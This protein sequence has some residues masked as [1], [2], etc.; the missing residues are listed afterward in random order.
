MILAV[1]I[2]WSS[3]QTVFKALPLH[4]DNEL[5][6]LV[7]LGSDQYPYKVRQLYAIV[8]HL[9]TCGFLGC[10]GFAC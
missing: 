9:L 2:H 10:V 6:S 1:L 5:Y 3:K 8:Q 7:F 4:T